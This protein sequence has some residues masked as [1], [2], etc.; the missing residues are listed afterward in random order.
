MYAERVTMRRVTAANPLA[1][2]FVAQSLPVDQDGGTPTG[3]ATC[4]CLHG[5]LSPICLIAF[6]RGLA[7][8]GM[9]FK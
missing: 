4:E 6:R 3:Q 8:A 9:R 2:V 5:R 1:V 7:C